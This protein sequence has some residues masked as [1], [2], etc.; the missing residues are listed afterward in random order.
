MDDAMN[1]S[2]HFDPDWK[3]AAEEQDRERIEAAL[4]FRQVWTVMLMFIAA[5]LLIFALASSPKSPRG[6]VVGG[7]ARIVL[8]QHDTLAPQP[9]H[10]SF[11]LYTGHGAPCIQP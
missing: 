9:P 2:E 11:D 1:G 5:W 8:R 4:P 3:E 6:S 7:P 10:F